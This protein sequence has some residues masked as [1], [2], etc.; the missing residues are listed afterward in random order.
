MQTD[1]L[2]KKGV[3]KFLIFDATYENKELLKNT[4]IFGMELGTKSKK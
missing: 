2:K 4:M 1:I 3:N